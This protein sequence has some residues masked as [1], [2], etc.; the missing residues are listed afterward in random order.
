MCVVPV[1]DRR[2]PSHRGPVRRP[3]KL[4][5][6]A[7]FGALA[8]AVH[9]VPAALASE[10]EL[11][12]SLRYD[13][14]ASARRCWDE[15]EF[16][17]S[18]AHRVGY[19]PFRDDASI[20]VSI[21]VGGS[22]H[23]V[24]GRVEWQNANGVE[25][26]E[27]RIA[28]KDGNCAK[29]L[30]EISFAV[31]LQIELLRPKTTA[32]DGSAASAG[33]SA[34]SS[35]GGGIASSAHAA[36][37]AGAPPAVRSSPAPPPATPSTTSLSPASPPTVTPPKSTPPP[38]APEP[39]VAAPEKERRPNDDAGLETEPEAA[40]TSARWPMWLGI[41][42]SLA[43][44]IAP[45]ITGSA[46]MFL[47]VRRNDL[48]VELGAEASYP[49]TE[50]RSD[51]SGFRQSLVGASAAVCGHLSALS[52]C[53][54]GKASQVRVSGLGVA[55]PRSPTGFL[56]QAGLRLAATLELAGPWSASAHVDALGLLTP[57]TVDLNQVSVWDMPRFGTLVG[58]DVAAHFR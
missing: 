33:D 12:V 27:R 20:H 52:A 1:E 24:D 37:G 45:S 9:P 19:D 26:G 57:C 32:G 11:Y 7:A 54:L 58:M 21:R 50:R 6:I 51:G 40:P 13:I 38:T 5:A 34:T 4:F 3:S 8:V 35:L 44:G 42:P 43:L 48:S 56:T 49:S 15:A 14:G 31:A 53:L 29:L 16:R 55:Q 22:P 10:P 23:A 2:P 36:T 39:E 47:G 30:T 25:M 41:G 17:Q 18:V 46:R 28:G